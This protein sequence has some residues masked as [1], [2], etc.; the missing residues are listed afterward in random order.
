VG[1]AE[2]S[3]FSTYSTTV[4]ALVNSHFIS[5][6]TTTCPQPRRCRPSTCINF[7]TA[8]AACM[9]H[10]NSMP[11]TSLSPM[12]GH[13]TWHRVS[14]GLC[15]WQYEETRPELQRDGLVP[16]MR[17]RECQQCPVTPVLP[18][19]HQVL[20]VDVHHMVLSGCSGRVFRVMVVR[21][22]VSL[23]HSRM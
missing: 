9:E 22:L 8:C 15:R 16:A 3:I 2:H 20:Q 13:S 17:V 1:T 10:T 14:H 6:R 11:L 18:V 12:T 4:N 21:W 23:L 5:C 7:G 19:Q